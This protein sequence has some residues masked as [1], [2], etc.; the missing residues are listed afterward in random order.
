M[1]FKDSLKMLSERV[2]KMKDN[3]LT[4]EA[5]KNALIMPFIQTLGYDVFNPLEV[6]PEYTCDIG[7][8]KGEK[9]DYAIIKDNE[10]ILLI[11]CKHH[12]QNLTLH[13]NQLLRYFHVSKA[14]FGVLTNGIEYRFYSDLD[15]SNKMDEKPFFT[16]NLADVKDN[17]YDELRKFHK[18]YFDIDNIVNSASELKYTKELKE[19]IANEMS[20][21]SEP[22][23]RLLTKQIYNGL[24]T[25]K[26]VELFGSLIKKS[27]NQIVNEEINDRLKSALNNDENKAQ[28]EESNAPVKCDEETT[29]NPAIVT[30]E[31]EMEGYFIVKSILRNVIDVNRI[32]HRDTQSYFGILCDD[33]NRKPICRLHFNSCNK[34]IGLFDT[35]KKER[36][37]LLNNLNDIYSYASEIEQTAKTYCDND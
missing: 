10:A 15:E 26:V 35:E 18:S 27:F 5:T 7:T 20:A 36:K 2:Y 14:K 25:A 29:A 19:L 12:S 30:T 31:E 34:Y 3:I 33:N 16:V 13:D 4:E 11:E 1:D 9:I 32:T 17:Q 6:V 21:P 23:V 8:K 37:V 24:V 28:T 22:L